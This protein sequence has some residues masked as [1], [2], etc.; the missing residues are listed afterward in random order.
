VLD[1]VRPG[2]IFDLWGKLEDTADLTG[3]LGDLAG[4]P[5]EELGRT[6]GDGDPTGELRLGATLV[7]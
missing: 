4:K 1:L 5:G 3:R 6:G 2:E 7:M